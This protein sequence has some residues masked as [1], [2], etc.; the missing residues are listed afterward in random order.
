MGGSPI[1]VDDDG[2]IDVDVD[3]D[4]GVDDIDVDVDND[5]D[6]GSMDGWPTVH[7]AKVE[8]PLA[9]Q[10]KLFLITSIFL[11]FILFSSMYF[12]SF[13][14]SFLIFHVHGSSRFKFQDP[15]TKYTGVPQ[16]TR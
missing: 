2:D 12:K 4:V 1:L 8:L 11:Q 15:L 10:P 6:G 14:N 5:D 3:V 16:Q 13:H 7:G 9:D